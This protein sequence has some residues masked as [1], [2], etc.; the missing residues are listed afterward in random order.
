MSDKKL[1]LIVDD[2]LINQKIIEEIL[3]NDYQLI[4]ADN[5]QE[6]LQKVYEYSPELVLLDVNMP[7]MTGLEACSCL[8]LQK[9]YSNL[10]IIFVSALVSDEERLEGYAVGADDYVTKPFN[11][12][13]LR[14]K[15][16]L[17]LQNKEKI[18]QLQQSVTE[19][20]SALESSFASRS[21]IST[22]VLFLRETSK[23]HSIKELADSVFEVLQEMELEACLY[24]QNKFYFSDGK[25]SPEDRNLINL[26]KENE[27]ILT[28]GQQAIF[29][30]PVASMLIRNMPV[31]SDKSGRYRDH[32]ALLADS[33]DA[34]VK[35]IQ[36][37]QQVIINKQKLIEL[38]KITRE[39]LGEVDSHH[40]HQRLEHTKI[41][42]D[43][44]LDMEELFLNLGLTEPQEIAIMNE[45]DF[46]E[47]DTDRLYDEGIDI[48]NI[49]NQ[50]I[51]KLSDSIK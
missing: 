4:F 40:K 32:L 37:E 51:N 28:I 9:Q 22:I 45:I 30:M 11:K 17:L 33:I 21:E 12:E 31:D 16:E 8:R 48:D 5:G 44:A 20:S 38:I 39:S 27:R 42:S 23:S 3:E 13:I 34:R 2:E 36:H 14:S 1:I 10:P 47:T 6:C 24:I 46:I 25:N 49:F 26:H 50:V 15:V 43:M 29:N 7:V 35:A 41:L 18:K 19:T